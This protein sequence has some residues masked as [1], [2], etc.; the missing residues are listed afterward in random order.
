[1]YISKHY[2]LLY[3][4]PLPSKHAVS[5]EEFCLGRLYWYVADD[6]CRT[7]DCP[8]LK[9]TYHWA[10]LCLTQQEVVDFVSSGRLAVDEQIYRWMVIERVAQLVEQAR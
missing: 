5:A 9:V 7:G 1:M 6:N 4:S 10:E 8:S 3:L 2:L